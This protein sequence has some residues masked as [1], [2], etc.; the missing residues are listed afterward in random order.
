MS[1]KRLE[2]EYTILRHKFR[3]TDDELKMVN[4]LQEQ[5][6][7]VKRAAMGEDDEE[8]G[9]IFMTRIGNDESSKKEMKLPELSNS[10]G[11]QGLDISGISDRKSVQSANKMEIPDDA[12]SRQRSMHSNS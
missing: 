4:S 10:R 12:P 11:M 6:D 7:A 1:V 5:I 8:D 9:D 2:K 3:S